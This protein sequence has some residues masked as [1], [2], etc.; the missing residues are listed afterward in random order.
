MAKL[1]DQWRDLPARQNAGDGGGAIG[2]QQRTRRRLLGHAMTLFAKQGYQPTTA[3]EIATAAG[4]SRATFFL[5]FPTKAALLGELS[6]ELAE[7]WTAETAPAGE[8][9]LEGVLR[10]MTFLFRETVSDAIGI[11]ILYDFVETYGDDMGAGSGA[12][13]LHD[14]AERMIARAQ[15][16]G[17]WSATW[18]A[19]ALAHYVLTAFNRFRLEMPGEAP[20]IAARA[21]LDLLCH[22]LSPRTDEH[23]I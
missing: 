21:L 11:A 9:G 10:F 17:A 22:G 2:K 3:A 13:T 12:G 4:V 7:S 15:G 14:H 8:N 16:E 5:H 18:S 23:T 6:R 19:S 20:E 1:I